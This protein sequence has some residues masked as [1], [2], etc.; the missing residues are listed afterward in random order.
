M[1]KSRFSGCDQ[2][3]RRPR[4]CIFAMASTSVFPKENKLKSI[5]FK[6]LYA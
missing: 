4:R 1:S 3:K 6:M 2:I 5:S